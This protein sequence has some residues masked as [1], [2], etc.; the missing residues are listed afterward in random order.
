MCLSLFGFAPFSY[1]HYQLSMVFKVIRK[2]LSFSHWKEIKT[3]RALR[4]KMSVVRVYKGTVSSRSSVLLLASPWFALL[5]TG[6][7]SAHASPSCNDKGERRLWIKNDDF[8]YLEYDPG[9]S[10]QWSTLHWRVKETHD[11]WGD[12]QP[13]ERVKLGKFIIEGRVRALW[14]VGAVFIVVVVV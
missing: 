7:C 12:I 9:S 4:R 13:R 5:K 2:C 1:I 8:A 11:I 3:V 10:F 6:S 14:T